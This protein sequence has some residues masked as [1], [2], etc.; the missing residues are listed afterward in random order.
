[1][2]LSAAIFVGES[3]K[4]IPELVEKAKKLR[5]GYGLNE[6]SDLGPVISP[7]AKQRIE[8]LI[9]SGVKQGAK[10]ELDGKKSFKLKTKFTSLDLFMWI[11]FIILLHPTLFFDPPFFH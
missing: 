2:A 5:V 1:M 10:L 3:K 4:W 11:H 8:S 6:G 9:E 7:Q